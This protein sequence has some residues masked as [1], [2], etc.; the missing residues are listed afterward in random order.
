MQARYYDPV[1]YS[2][3]NPVGSFNRYSYINNN[4]YKYTDPSGMCFWDLC[5]IEATL[6]TEAA[7]VVG[8]AVAVTVS[9]YYGSE[10]INAY[11]EAGEPD[12]GA[13]GDLPS[14]DGLSGDEAV[15]V[16]EENGFEDR[17]ETQNDQ[18]KETSRKFYH[19]DGS[20]VFIG[21]EGGDVKVTG[22]HQPKADGSGGKFTPRL[23]KDRKLMQNDPSKTSHVTGEKV[24]W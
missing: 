1:G 10:L 2:P 11:N 23:D 12:Y 16:L 24:N 13:S 14:L 4:P 9:A 5:V 18:G 3:N 19:P 21:T 17:G 22:K 15:G 8:T 6:A 7:I 20:K